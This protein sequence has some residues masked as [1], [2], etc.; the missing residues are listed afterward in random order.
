MSAEEAKKYSGFYSSDFGRAVL[1]KEVEFVESRL[2]GH[3]NILS[4]GCGPALLETRLKMHHPPMNIIGLDSSKQMIAQAEKS[5][6]LVCGDAEHLGFRANIFDAVMYV[7]SLEFIRD[8]Q[9][10]LEETHRVLEPAGTI[11]ILTLNP[12]SDYFKDEY[13]QKGSYIRKN[14]KHMDIAEMEEFVS[15]YFFLGRQGYFLGIKNGEIVDSD[16][17]DLSSLYVLEGLT[18]GK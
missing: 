10:A 5:I 8:C 14:I 15:G 3:R 18:R 16:T 12:K 2:R 9:K 17:P 4:I 1:T 13:R 7:T 11:L 6:C